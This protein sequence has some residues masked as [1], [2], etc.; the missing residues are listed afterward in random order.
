MQILVLVMKKSATNYS[1]G[2]PKNSIHYANNLPMGRAVADKKILPSLTPRKE[3]YFTLLAEIIHI[4]PHFFYRTYS[5]AVL[6]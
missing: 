4:L 6:L 2:I 5:R 3:V 1:Q